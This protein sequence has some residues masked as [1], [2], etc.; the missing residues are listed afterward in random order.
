VIPWIQDYRPLQTHVLLDPDPRDAALHGL[1]PFSLAWLRQALPQNI[2]DADRLTADLFQTENILTTFSDEDDAARQEHL[3]ALAEIWMQQFLKARTRHGVANLIAPFVLASGLPTNLNGLNVRD[4]ALSLIEDR[5]LLRKALHRTFET[6]GLLS[7][8]YAT[9]GG[10]VSG[11]LAGSRG[12]FE[13]KYPIHFLL[14]DD[15]FNLGFHHVLAYLL[16]GRR[17]KAKDYTA[18]WAFSCPDAGTLRCVSSSD[19]L[20]NSFGRT[21]VTDWNLPRVFSPF[22]CDVLLLDLRLWREDEFVKRCELMEK[23]VG[24]YTALGFNKIGSL[25]LKRAYLS[26]KAS[27][28]RQFLNSEAEALALLPLLVSYYD[29]SFPIIIFSS[30]QQRAV[31]EL[32]KHRPN[33]ITDFTKPGAVG[34]TDP[35]SAKLAIRDLELAIE[36]AIA[37]HEAR[38]IWMRLPDLQVT[39][40]ALASVAPSINPADVTESL[41]RD[42]LRRILGFFFQHYILAERYFDFISAPWELIE[43]ILGDARIDSRGHGWLGLA[44][45]IRDAARF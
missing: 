5:S 39:C 10:S 15:Q 45:P 18:E 7:P 14:V 4:R 27:I 25:Q 21:K 11:I 44:R 35:T 6:V 41:E 33:I 2:R 13:R 16:F 23:L 36:K 28:D 34:A 9:R 37:L 30:T 12:V 31:I 17:Y 22:G 8:E 24:I 19:R 3:R 29:P 40:A 26:A 38:I 1:D 20:L 43:W 42:R 32:L